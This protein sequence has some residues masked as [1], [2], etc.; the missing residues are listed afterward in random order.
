MSS[1]GGKARFSIFPT[2]MALTSMKARLVGA[3]KGHALLKKKSQALTLKYQGILKKMVEAKEAMGPKM[4]NAIFSVTQ[5]KYALPAGAKL[6]DLVAENVSV[7]RT[8]VNSSTEN[9]V[10]VK[11]PVFEV[12]YQ[13]G[14]SSSST[15]GGGEFYGL[16][17]GGQQIDVCRKEFGEAV[18]LLVELASMQTSYLAL[19]TALKVTNRRVNALEHVITPRIENTIAYIIEE[20]GEMEREEFF[21]LKRS[22][23]KKKKDAEEEVVKAAILAQEKAAAA[24]AASTNGASHFDDDLLNAFDN[25]VKISTKPVLAATPAAS[26]GAN[27]ISFDDHDKDIL[28]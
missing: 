18:T 10:G 2:R 24:A 6:S 13:G 26:A 16:A 28:F 23:A 12:A 19:D 27:L 15:G 21:R 3:T 8:T 9:V 11:L 22:Q 17:K 25:S 1:G 5:A 7:A 20:L 14:S 4:K